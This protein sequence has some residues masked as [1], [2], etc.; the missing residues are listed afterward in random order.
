MPAPFY[1]P[2]QLHVAQ[3][4]VDLCVAYSPDEDDYI[5]NIFFPRRVVAHQSDLIRQIDKGSL[6]RLYDLDMSTNGIAPTVSFATGANLTYSCTPFAARAAISPYDSANADAALQ[7]DVRAT[8]QA[9]LSMGIR[10]EYKAVNSTLRQ[11]SVM[12]SNETLAAAELWDNYGSTSS[13]PVDDL[14]AAVSQIRAKV[15]KSSRNGKGGRVA[16][17]MH[18]FVW[19]RVKQHP[20]V[21]QRL[22]FTGGAGAVLTPAIFASMIDLNSADDLH[23]TAAQYTSAAE[24]ET[25]AFKAFIGADVVCAYVDDGGL[26]DYCLGHE[27]AFNGLVG[28]DPFM[29][30]KYRVEQE[31][32]QGTDYVQV[33]SS[34]DYKATNPSEAGFLFKTVVD[35]SNTELYAGL[36]D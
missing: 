4:L 24:G 26:D 10:M 27:F 23:I 5:R 18:Q 12:T 1:S 7:F 9:L 36:L 2:S 28:S 33:A 3:P 34:I 21:I 11:T 13:D 29:V 35:T 15:G 20:N 25:N 30:R 31:G 16:V 22:I 17:A 32:I 19:D 14:I 8:K 6:I